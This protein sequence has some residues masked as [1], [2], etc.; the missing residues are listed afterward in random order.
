[1]GTGTRGEI[2]AERARELAKLS[3]QARFRE[4]VK[5]LEENGE[6]V[7]ET[8]DGWTPYGPRLDPAEPG[9]SRG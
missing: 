8:E 2:P 5:E 3:P 9:G 7:E 4:L 1:M 6:E